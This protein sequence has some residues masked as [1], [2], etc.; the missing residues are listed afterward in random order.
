VPPQGG[1]KHSQQEFLQ[2]D[3][4]NILFICGGALGGLD[5][6]Y[7]GA[8]PGNIHWLRSQRAGPENRK[9]G[10]IFREFEPEDLLK[11]GLIPEFVRRSAAVCPIA[12]WFMRS[13]RKRSS[14]G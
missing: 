2:V 13:S 1:R 7:F 6:D 11:Y 5:E 4:A 9:T 14:T 12:T 10:E 8:R 3:T